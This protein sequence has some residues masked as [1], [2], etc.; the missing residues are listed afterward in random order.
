MPQLKVMLP[1]LRSGM[2]GLMYLVLII[3][4]LQIY[5]DSKGHFL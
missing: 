4:D 1:T 5:K 2:V 3:S